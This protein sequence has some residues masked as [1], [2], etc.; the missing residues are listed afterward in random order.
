VNGYSE[1]AEPLKQGPETALTGFTAHPAAAAF[2]MLPDDELRALADDIL[3]GGLR[4]PIV[5]MG[6]QILDGRN[7]AK[8]CA[9]AGVEPRTVDVQVDDPI[10][11]VISANLA[12]RHLTTAQRAAIAADLATMKRTDTLKQNRADPSNEGAVSMSAARAAKALKVSV[13]SVE[14]AKAV[15]RD[16]PEEHKRVKA[17]EKP[18]RKV[19][20]TT[21]P[22]PAGEEALGPA[23]NGWRATPQQ[24]TSASSEGKQ[25]AEV[26]R[27]A[28]P[29]DGAADEAPEPVPAARSRRVSIAIAPAYAALSRLH[30]AVA[31][32]LATDRDIKADFEASKL[33]IRLY[34]EA[35]KSFPEDGNLP[36]PRPIKARKEPAALAAQ[37]RVQRKVKPAKGGA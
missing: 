15:A 21:S 1:P 8:A 32:F 10:S 11:F 13:A 19:R 3:A 22:A 29:G 7:R 5:V 36:K 35:V 33:A 34:D 23:L 30:N 18:T 2:P 25:Q 16:D 12:R 17:G 20:A 26:E 4:S 28:S 37:A 27:Q 31:E 14:R 9:L 6:T 24:P